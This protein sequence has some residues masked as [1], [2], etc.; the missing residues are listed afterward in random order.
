VLGF[1]CTAGAETGVAT[2]RLLDDLALDCDVTSDAATFAADVTL[3]PGAPLPG[4]LCTP[5]ADG[6]S[7]CAAIT[8]ADPAQVDADDYL[9]QAA[10]YRGAEAL[11]SGGGLA[12]KVYWNVAL[13][14][15]PG[16]SACTLHSAGTADDGADPDDGVTAN[17]DGDGGQVAAGLVYPQVTWE[18]P[19]AACGSEAL[20]FGDP[21]APVRADYTDI[22]AAWPT[23]FDH[24]FAPSE[25]ATRSAACT[26]LPADAV[27]DTVD[28]IVQ[29]WDGGAWVPT[30]VGA[31][32]SSETTTACHFVCAVNTVWTDGGCVPLAAPPSLAAV[33]PDHGA[34]A[35]G[36]LV[37][38]VGTN[39]AVG[40]TVAFD[41]VASPGV[42][43]QSASRLVARVPA[44]AAPGPVVATVTNPD[45]GAASLA[46]AYTYGDPLTI[47]VCEKDATA[48]GSSKSV[49]IYY[50]DD[51]CGGALPAT[52]AEGAVRYAH[53]TNGFTNVSAVGGASPRMSLWTLTTGTRGLELD[54]VYFP[55]A[56][57]IRCSKSWNPGAVSNAATT[58]SAAN[59]GGT[60]PDSSYVGVLS[61]LTPYAG[62]MTFAV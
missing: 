20:T 57:A 51:D 11:T 16:I 29:T 22:G 38:L 58:F 56:G 26:G 45:T 28:T 1:A 15:R 4:N 3:D 13:G 55:A 59:C 35:G 44:G 31:F 10:V 42:T 48:T 32:D 41:G 50:S 23:D 62:A 39:L 40:A 33:V 37:T 30:N 53:A 6:M 7:P 2:T 54:A 9:F 43:R 12:H 5:G 18:V 14:V 24:R 46:A 17:P 52:D 21:T 8:E 34:T 47:R 19:L 25:A 36:D 49:A 60:L 27:W 61:S